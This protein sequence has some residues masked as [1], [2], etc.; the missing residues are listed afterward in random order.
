VL[1]RCP[2][3]ARLAEALAK[4]DVLEID[5]LPDG[6]LAV[7]GAP[8]QKVAETALEAGVAIYELSEEKA[9]LEQVFLRLTSGQFAGGPPQ[10][11]PPQYSQPGPPQYSQPGYGPPPGPPSGYGP[12]PGPPPGYGPPPGQYPP[13]PPGP[14]GPPPGSGQYPP[15]QGGPP[16]NWGGR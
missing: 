1:V 7:T 6:R 5:T 4:A 3:P 16:P 14:Y 8:L 2:D 9:D 12:P 15:A 10:Q 11:G 13:Q